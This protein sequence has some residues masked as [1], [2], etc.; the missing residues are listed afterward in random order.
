MFMRCRKSYHYFHN[1]RYK[2]H[3]INFCWCSRS[4]LRSP[5]NHLLRIFVQ[6]Q[7]SC[8]QSS[9]NFFCYKGLFCVTSNSLSTLFWLSFFEFIAIHRWKHTIFAFRL[10]TKKD[11]FFSFYLFSK[12]I[13]FWRWCCFFITLRCCLQQLGRWIRW[14]WQLRWIFSRCKNNRDNSRNLF[15]I[16]SW[17]L[18]PKCFLFSFPLMNL[19]HIAVFCTFF[20]FVLSFLS[21]EIFLLSASSKSEPFNFFPFLRHFHMHIF[22]V[23]LFMCL[24][25][26]FSWFLKQFQSCS[27]CH[28]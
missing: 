25:I 4:Y 22:P 12:I 15:H 2:F 1:C 13:L 10:A 20:F 14:W 9:Q 7:H 8:F 26:S 17:E 16:P 6:R 11:V 24:S 3:V 21:F 28:F 19:L 18:P 23:F 5:D 27:F